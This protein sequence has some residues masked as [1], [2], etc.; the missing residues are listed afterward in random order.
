[1]PRITLEVQEQAPENGEN[2]GGGA[3]GNL[4]PGGG[5]GGGSVGGPGATNAMTKRWIDINWTYTEPAPEGACTG[6]EVAVFAGTD[7]NDANAILAVPIEYIDDPAERRH[8]LLLELRTQ[9]QLRAAVRACYSAFRSSWTNAD[10]TATFTPDYEQ[11]QTDQ[12]TLTLPDGTIMQWFRSGQLTGQQDHVI[13]WPKPFPTE[14]YC[15]SVTTE[16]VSANAGNDSWI[17]LRSKTKTSVTVYKQ[18]ARN[19][20]N[21]MPLRANIVGWGR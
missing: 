5:G 11:R 4:N 18:S 2:P 15:V 16:E 14:C 12:G 19:E 8:L 10:A 3:G 6:F 9:I 7:I 21:N 13:P 17:V 20:S 1:M